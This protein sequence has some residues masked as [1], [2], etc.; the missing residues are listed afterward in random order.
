MKKILLLLIKLYQKFLSP[1]K[2]RTC[3]FY[4]SCSTYFYQ[5]I[6][7][8]GIVK[9]MWLGIKRLLRCN[10]FHKGGYDPIPDK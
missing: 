10:P 4:P 8:F 1:L 2:P 9:G 3:R 5:A 7:K 6:L